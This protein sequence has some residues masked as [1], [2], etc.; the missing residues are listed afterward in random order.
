VHGDSSRDGSL[1]DGAGLQFP[2]SAGG[3]IR[4]GQD[5]EWREALCN[6]A[7]QGWNREIRCSRK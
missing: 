2:A 6:Q 3:A 4:L 7:L 5:R 1:F